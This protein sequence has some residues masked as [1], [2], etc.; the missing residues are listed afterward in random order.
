MTEMTAAEFTDKK[1]EDLTQEVQKLSDELF[2]VRGER[3]G[4]RRLI[5]DRTGPLL[6]LDFT[7]SQVHLLLE[8]I[9]GFVLGLNP[10]KGHS[11]TDLLALATI[12]TNGLTLAE[13]GCPACEPGDVCVEPRPP[14]C[15]I[16]KAM[17]QP[18]V[19]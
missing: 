13:R 2:F 19:R 17:N 15:P 5:E 8:L 6:S 18:L 9:P 12:L 11:K 16:R 14:V 10:K 3:D 4:Y 1:I 7:P